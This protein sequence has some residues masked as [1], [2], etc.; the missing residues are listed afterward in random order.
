MISFPVE[1]VEGE[2]SAMLV[3]IVPVRLRAPDVTSSDD[4]G[5]G[6]GHNLRTVETKAASRI[7]GS[8]KTV[9]VFELFVI[10]IED[11]HRIHTADAER[12]REFNLDEG[13]RGAFP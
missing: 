11:D 10:E 13:L 5:V 12:A 1:I 6:I 2:T 9:T 3:E 8:G 4:A 7:P